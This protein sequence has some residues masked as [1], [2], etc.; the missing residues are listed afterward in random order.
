[1]KTAFET[2]DLVFDIHAEKQ[3]SLPSLT[4]KGHDVV[5]CCC[6]ESELEYYG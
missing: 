1:M 5:F 3:S 4:I 6:E 2:S